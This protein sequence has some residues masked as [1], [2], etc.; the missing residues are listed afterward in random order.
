MGQKQVSEEKQGF[1]I[2]EN[3]GALFQLKKDSEDRL[4]FRLIEKK[5]ISPD[6]FIYAYEIPENY[7][8]VLIFV[9]TLL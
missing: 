5:Q 2:D 7:T 1:T 9:S 8:L 6:T 4:S 3:T